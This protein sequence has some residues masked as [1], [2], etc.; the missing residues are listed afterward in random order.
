MRTLLWA[1]RQKLRRSNMVW[2]AFFATVLLAAIVLIGGQQV[3]EGAR[4]ID[5]PGWFLSV[6]QPWATML[7]LPAVI[8]LLGSYMICREQQDDTL[9][10]LR[11]IPINEAKLT[12]AKMILA[13]VICVLLY[14]LLFVLAFAAEAALHAPALP[15]GMVL[16]FLKAY[17][18]DGVA[19]F[20]AI[21]PIIALVSRNKNGYWLA[22]VFTELYSFTGMFTSM[23]NT[24][25]AI[26][27]MTAV[28]GLSGYYGST[29]GQ[30]ALSCIS[31]LACGMLAV[32][33]LAGQSKAAAD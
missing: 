12:V 28:F 33:I 6:L 10:T 8:A 32:I 5:K 19:V 3:Y 4:Y 20:F 9:K 15:A 23:S 21:S 30:F 1:E 24:L 29:P 17:L 18:I 11:L 14:L 26:Y 13:F 16:G 25:R 2:V 31:L 7:A 22:L 27:P